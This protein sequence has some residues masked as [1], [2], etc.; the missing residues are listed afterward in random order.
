MVNLLHIIFICGK[1]K[2]IN[3]LPSSVFIELKA[4]LQFNEN[5]GKY[6]QQCYETKQ[7]PN[8]NNSKIMKYF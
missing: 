4:S 8:K 5:T 2:I 3:F 7:L 6:H 1:T